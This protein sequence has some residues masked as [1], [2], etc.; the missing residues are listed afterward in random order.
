MKIRGY[1]YILECADGGYYTGS[2]KD[3]IRRLQQHMLGESANHTRKR[4]PVK[5]A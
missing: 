2:T 4:L 5:L 1:M 3:L